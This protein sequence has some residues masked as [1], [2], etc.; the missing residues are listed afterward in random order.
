[1]K[2]RI[3]NVALLYSA[4]AMIGILYYVIFRKWHLGLPCILNSLTGLSCPGCGLT[5]A[6]V[7]ISR[8]DFLTALSLNCLIYLYIAYGIWFVSTATVRYIKGKQDP[9]IFG[10][11][12]V[13]IS[14]LAL[15]AVFGIVRN[16]IG[17]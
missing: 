14:I 13:H 1:M 9:L 5:R 8:G 17:I 2:K 16:I 4:I 15:A 12:F 11:N 7:A 3:R 6:I 10:P